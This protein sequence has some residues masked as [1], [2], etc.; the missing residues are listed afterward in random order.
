[1]ALGTKIGNFRGKESKKEG[2]GEPDKLA[3]PY[4]LMRESK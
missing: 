2:V 4:L 3:D 1:M